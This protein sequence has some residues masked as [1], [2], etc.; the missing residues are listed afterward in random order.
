M[1]ETVAIGIKFVCHFNMKAIIPVAGAGTKLRPLT[2]TQPK[3]LIPVAGKPIISF[4]LDQLILTETEEFIFVIGYMGEKIK[5]YVQEYYPKIKKSF[6]LQEDRMGLGQ[7]I[8]SCQP[9]INP[10]D[11][12]IIQLGDSILDMDYQ[13]ISNS[14]H[15]TLAVRKV[16]DPRNFGVV[17]LNDKGYVM[18]LVE[19][20]LI[21]KS[22]LALVGLY[23]IKEFGNLFEALDYNIRNNLKTRD[24]FHLTD[25]LMRMVEQGHILDTMEVRNWFDCGKKEVLLQNNA[26]LLER[27]HDESRIYDFPG[28][29]I[30]PPV[31]IGKNCTIKNSIIG[32][33][34][35]IGDSAQIEHAILK[36]AIIGNFTVIAD[37]V[38]NHSIIGNDA[39]IRGKFQSFNI[40]DNTEIDMV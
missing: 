1:L 17:E 18:R 7:A 9:L 27:Q 16:S 37:L 2:Y 11:E 22:N 4:I 5:A 26:I 28:T 20:P 15:S 30:V 35:T 3:P 31:S 14:R 10:G 24:E 23:F 39:V 29:I 19:K 34:V 8:H 25:G 33:S 12:V 6:I 21:P 38:L 40:G 36:D 32:P 13:V